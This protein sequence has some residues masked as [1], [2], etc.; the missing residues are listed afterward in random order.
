MSPRLSLSPRDR[1]QRTATYRHARQR[2]AREQGVEN[3]G[4]AGDQQRELKIL[5]S[6]VQSPSLPTIIFPVL[7]GIT[8][9]QCF[10][11]NSSEP[12]DLPQTCTICVTPS[13]R[14]ARE[15]AETAMPGLLQPWH[16]RRTPGVSRRPHSTSRPRLWRSGGRRSPSCARP[17]PSPQNEGYRP[18]QGCGWPSA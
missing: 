10:D 15:P 5:V 6:A 18:V 3:A 7:S 16:C 14:S 12:S 9:E 1:T 8:E 11:S 2:P 4:D 13:R 17:S